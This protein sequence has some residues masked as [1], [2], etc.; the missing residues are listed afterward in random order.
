MFHVFRFPEVCHYIQLKFLNQVRHAIVPCTEISY[1]A[2]YITSRTFHMPFKKL[3]SLEN[4]INVSLIL[5]MKRIY[6]SPP[7]L[8]KKTHRKVEWILK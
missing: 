3:P 6:F 8:K 1:L 4:L 2:H 5:D 7:R